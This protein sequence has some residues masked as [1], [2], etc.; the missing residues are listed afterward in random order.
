MT[1][2]NNKKALHHLFFFLLGNIVC[3]VLCS[4]FFKCENTPTNNIE[5]VDCQTFVS[6]PLK[7]QILLEPVFETNFYQEGDYYLFD[8]TLHFND[9]LDFTG[10][11]SD[12]A[13]I[14]VSFD[15]NMPYS[16]L[17]EEYS[18]VEVPLENGRLPKLFQFR[19]DSTMNLVY[20]RNLESLEA[21]LDDTTSSFM[22]SINVYNPGG[23]LVQ[24]ANTWIDR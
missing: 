19:L 1:A 10:Y 8:F 5:K 20:G 22:M 23:I 14:S 21:F 24:N 16:I 12:K 13:Y 17:N 15:G 18:Y 4:L 11:E 3:F 2:L 7:D 9:G 6:E